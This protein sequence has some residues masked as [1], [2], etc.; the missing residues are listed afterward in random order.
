MKSRCVAEE[1]DRLKCLLNNIDESKVVLCDELLKKASFLKVELNRLE[2]HIIKNGVMETS[3]RGNTRISNQYKTYLTSLGVYQ[4][5]IRTINNVVG[6]SLVDEDDEF[7]E[8][9]S[10]VQVR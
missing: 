6:K 4:S 2:S 5:L 1:Y 9:L 10:K 8:F 7:D 3:T